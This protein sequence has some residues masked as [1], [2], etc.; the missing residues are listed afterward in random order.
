MTAH[1]PNI[2]NTVK[3]QLRAQ[4]GHKCANP[5]CSN[6]RTHIHHIREW[7]VYQTHDAKHMIAVC[8]SCHDAIHH[9]QIPIDDAVLYSWK[10]IE[11][12]SASVRGH[13][14]V[15]PGD[16][17]KILLGTIAVTAPL[18]AVVFKLSPNNSLKF[19]IKDGDILLLDLAVSTLAG[20][21]VLRVSDNHVKHNPRHDVEFL[22]VPGSIK[23]TSPCTDEFLP[24]WAVTHMQAQEPDFGRQGRLTTLGLTVLK[25]G[26]ARVEGVWAQPDRAVIVT[27]THLS[28]L[29]P[30]LKQPISLVGDGENSVLN[31]V[32]SGVIDIPLF[33]FDRASTLNVGANR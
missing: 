14:Y 15:E 20:T 13:I 24:S 27:Q 28:F 25:P 18:K 10:T 29:R 21:E 5:G 32:G 31:Y 16:T 7:A 1:R 23:V 30:D 22:Q 4:A 2:S 3:K 6:H 12:K 19:T 17:A 33:G 26:L 8:P 9:G 11:R